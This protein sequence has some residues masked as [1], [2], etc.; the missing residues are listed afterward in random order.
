MYVKEPVDY[1]SFPTYDDAL[2]HCIKQHIQLTNATGRWEAAKIPQPDVFKTRYYQHW[3][4]KIND[5]PHQIVKTDAGVFWTW[6]GTIDVSNYDCGAD[7]RPIKRSPP[8]KHTY[9]IAVRSKDPTHVSGAYSTK[10]EAI[11]A[12]NLTQT[13]GGE[14]HP[15][16]SSVMYQVIPYVAE[17]QE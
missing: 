10:A 7:Y 6:C 13:L 15:R 11:Q 3:T 12:M 17:I 8:T 5:A 9:W 1:F 14:Y 4:V 16:G 2:Q